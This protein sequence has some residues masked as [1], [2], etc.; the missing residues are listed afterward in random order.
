MEKTLYLYKVLED[1]ILNTDIVNKKYKSAFLK[2]V[3]KLSDNNIEKVI[4][5]LLKW[6]NEM[7]NIKYKYQLKRNIEENRFMEKV[8]NENFIK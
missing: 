8:I 2:K 5:H 3:L 7:E 1:I 4:N 6:L